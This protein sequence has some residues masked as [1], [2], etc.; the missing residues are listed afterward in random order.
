MP[1][2]KGKEIL[3]TQTNYEYMLH[4]GPAKLAIFL[5]T[6][7]AHNQGC[8]PVPLAQVFT[9]CRDSTS[10]DECWWGWLLAEFEPA[11]SGDSRAAKVPRPRCWDCRWGVHADSTHPIVVCMTKRFH[12]VHM[13]G[14]DYCSFFAEK[15]FEPDPVDEETA[16]KL[17]ELRGD[18]KKD[19]AAEMQKRYELKKL[20]SERARREKEEES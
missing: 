9:M 13:D 20:A 7:L 14:D 3:K 19:F 10:C 6:R 5:R 16:K 8:P 1:T 17:G 2:N 4:L 11:P 12:G 18:N 15:Y